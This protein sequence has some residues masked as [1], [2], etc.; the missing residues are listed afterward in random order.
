MIC[1]LK[2]WI[3][4]FLPYKYKIDMELPFYNNKKIINRK[5]EFG[6]YPVKLY[7]FHNIDYFLVS[8]GVLDF[9]IIKSSAII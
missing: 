3:K 4:I 7:Q 8:E 6:L 1:S 9:Y 2:C 5:R